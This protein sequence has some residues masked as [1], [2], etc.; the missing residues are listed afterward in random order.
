MTNAHTSTRAIGKLEHTLDTIR[1]MRI[2]SSA[3]KNKAEY[4]EKRKTGYKFNDIDTSYIEPQRYNFTTMLQNTNTYEV[5][6][7]A[8]DKG[9]SITFAPEANIRIGPYFGWRWIFLGYTVDITHLLRK[10]NDKH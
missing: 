6:R 1:W 5:Y 3:Y 9:Q 7:I 2:D 10:I 8:S 4:H